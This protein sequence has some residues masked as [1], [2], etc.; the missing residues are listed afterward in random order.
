MIPE[1]TQTERISALRERITSEIF[2]A[3]GLGRS[4]FAPRLL[5]PLFRLPAGR[6]AR[7]ADHLESAVPQGGLPAG[8][9]AILDDFSMK[10]EA[11]GTENIP[12]SGP[13]LIISNHPGAYDSPAIASAIPRPD[14]KIIASDVPFTR[15]L[16]NTGKHLI[17]APEDIPGR[18]AALKAG[19]DHLRAGGAVLSF[20]LGEVEPDPAVMRG[21]GDRFHEWSPS[22][23]VMLRKV[24]ATRLVIC[25]ASGVMLK[26]FVKSPLTKIRRQPF[27]QQKMGELLQILQQ[28]LF[29]KSFKINVQI[30]FGDPISTGDLPPHGLMPEVAAAARRQLEEHI[31]ANNLF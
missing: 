30:T 31:Q 1:P 27:H 8:A 26:K 2:F 28:M 12:Q 3:M 5:G 9:Q 21:A 24:T 17:Y 18:M 16:V 22:I 4:G 11:R 19:V 25:I 20:P 10:V 7:I 13:L 23:E 14:L 15:A 6:F 29:P